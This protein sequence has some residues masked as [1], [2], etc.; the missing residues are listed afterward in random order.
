MV[1]AKKISEQAAIS[2]GNA[3]CALGLDVES[4]PM[5]VNIAKAIALRKKTTFLS[6]KTITAEEAE[7]LSTMKEDSSLF[8]DDLESISDECAE[9]LFRHEGMLAMRGLKSISEQALS[10]L[11]QKKHIWLKTCGPR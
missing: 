5:T 11:E 8:L 4:M 10:L 1:T 6:I 2:L 7:I 9:H 3:E